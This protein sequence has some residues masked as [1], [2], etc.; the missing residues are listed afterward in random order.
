MD[1]LQ[2]NQFRELMDVRGGPCVSVYLPT[3]PAGPDAEQDMVRLKNLLRQAEEE[4]ADGWLRAPEARDLL[5]AARQLPVDA[6]Y[7]ADRSQGLAIFAAKDVFRS[8][9]LPVA[10]DEYVLVNERFQLK[11]LLPVVSAADRYLVLALSQNDVRLLEGT[12]RGLT[13][14][15]VPDMPHDIEQALNYSEVPRGSQVHSA[16]RA[17][18]RNK[19]AAV[20]HGQGGEPET[21]KL[22][23]TAYLRM[24]DAA[25]APVL[26]DERAPLLLAG[27]DYL[28]PIYREVNRYPHLVDRE[29]TGNF[30]YQSDFEIHQRAWSIVEPLFLGDRRKAADRYCNLAGTGKTFDD[31]RQVVPAAEQGRIDTLFVDRRGHEWGRCDAGALAAEVHESRRDGDDDLLDRAAVETLLNRG[32][33]YAVQRDEVPSRTGVA[34]LLRY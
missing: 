29:L 4:L 18:G 31:I 3:H 6:A 14:I 23:L 19:Q 11:P 28:M 22:D 25:L 32:T 21:H 15:E 16:A 17:A 33:V 7:W 13:P 12:R 9:R 5:A 34:A 8:W 20:F 10:F 26:R 2:L 30:D 1:T 27:V 24:V